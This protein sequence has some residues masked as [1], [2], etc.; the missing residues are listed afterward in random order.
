M[1]HISSCSGRR[2]SRSLSLSVSLHKR[3]TSYQPRITH[4]KGNLVASAE[5]GRESSDA[6]VIGDR[7]ED[8]RA[9][10]YCGTMG[11]WGEKEMLA[12]NADASAADIS[13]M[14]RLLANCV[15]TSPETLATSRMLCREIKGRAFGWLG[16]RKKPVSP[17]LRSSC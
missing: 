17:F 6:V 10:I 15:C 2:C 9:S 5:L 7:P 16:H 12:V 1:R 14:V 8:I 3:R 4:R 13:D 11:V